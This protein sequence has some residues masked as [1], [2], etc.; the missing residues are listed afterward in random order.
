[1]AT[2]AI[3]RPMLPLAAALAAGIA[4]GA[5]IPGRWIAAVALTALSVLVVV[6]RGTID[7][8][9]QAA[10]PLILIVTL[11]YLSVQPWLAPRLGP[12]HAAWFVDGPPVAVC[13]TV[14]NEPRVAAGRQKFVLALVR[15]EGDRAAGPQHGCVRVTVQG[16]SPVISRGDTLAF[17]T[18]LKSLR[19]FN[20][21]GGFDYR[22]YLYLQGV[23]A[24]AYVSADR[25]RRQ[26]PADPDGRDDRGLA[27]FR[28]RIAVLA[29]GAA[30][31]DGAAVLTALTI[32]DR[33]RVTDDLRNVFNR[34]GVGH[35][36]AISGLH[37]GIV[38][39]LVFG[40]WV[41]ALIWCPFML[42]RAWTTKTAALG[43][44]AA[45]WGYSLLAGL[46][47]STQRAAIMVSA[48]LAA[49]LI[50][51]D[52][53]LPSTLALAALTILVVHPP[54]LF[55]ISFQLSFAAVAWILIGMHPDPEAIP[56]RPQ[57]AV[58]RLRRRA[59]QFFW[60]SFWAITGTLPL[61]IQAFNQVSLV[62][63]AAN[64]IFVPWIGML[65]VPL[66]LAG[67][68]LALVSAPAAAL[69]FSTCA[70]LLNPALS[71]LRILAD[72]PYSAV[73]TFTPRAVEIA[74]YYAALAVAVVWRRSRHIAGGTPAHGRRVLAGSLVVLALL[75]DVLYWGHRRYWHRDIRATV[76]DVGQGAATV[77]ELPAG[78]VML[79][80]GGGF[81][82]NSVFDV[83]RRVVAPFLRYQK[84]FTVDMVVLTH[85]NAD[86][87]NGLLYILEHFG[88]GAVWSNHEA[89]D[90]LGYRRFQEIIARRG[91]AWPPFGNLSGCRRIG[92]ARV[93]VIY[94][95]ADFDRRRTAEPWRSG[96]NGSIVVRVSI[97]GRTILLTGDIEE[98]AEN[99]LV[100]TY[101]QALRADVLLVPHH[102][103]RTS[104]GTAL[105]TAVRPRIALISCGWRNPYGMP[106]RE[107]LQRLESQGTTTWRTD[108]NGAIHLTLDTENLTVRPFLA[109][110]SPRPASSAERMEIRSVRA[111]AH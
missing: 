87:L 12:G 22:R 2:E 83:G 3:H 58:A 26:A 56:T 14:V 38:A 93:E 105:L 8:R 64:F 54:A 36:L 40:L 31:P 44:A 25:L 61:V 6:V 101:P 16:T 32:G 96:N 81:A 71:L 9:D 85:P 62:G 65:V 106:H 11:G 107:V 75:A 67:T 43:T 82:D 17:S 19:N 80:D 78:K 21:P 74:I 50:E 92:Q 10:A 39:A 41:R 99:E 70:A 47:P 97:G 7:G 88:V 4:T 48:Y 59:R 45:V 23:R 28:R 5:W 57:G 63:L 13:G 89:A 52:A 84:I 55:G 33:R 79:V 15:P 109:A 30:D 91:L 73:V 69:V 42:E 66:A 60:V 103:S 20:N 72:W 53:D 104:T 68:V 51:R 35:L 18:R 94:P 29:D 98:P 49:L 1:M 46:S 108:H 111:N 76:L 86:H 110:P 77:L 27:R 95:P 37:V 100:A 34:T 90:T 102:G 24:T